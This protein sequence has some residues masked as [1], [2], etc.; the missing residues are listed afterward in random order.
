MHQLCSILLC[1]LVI[2]VV[3][4]IIL[5]VVWYLLH[6]W[7]CFL[8]SS[9]AGT[10]VGMLI[11]AVVL[12]LIKSGAVAL[13]TFLRRHNRIVV[14]FAWSA[15]IRR[16][17]P[18][19]LVPIH[20][21]VCVIHLRKDALARVNVHTGGVPVLVSHGMAANLRAEQAWEARLN[22]YG[23]ACGVSHYILVCYQGYCWGSVNVTVRIYLAGRLLLVLQIYH[24]IAL[25]KQ[26]I[27]PLS[28][29]LSDVVHYLYLLLCSGS[30]FLLLPGLL[31]RDAGVHGRLVDILNLK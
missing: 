22:D 6:L 30:C 26:F 31:S 12:T 3:A 7:Q 14:L 4:I 19:L 2:I 17:L 1:S 20:I 18:R 9:V 5:I 21:L 13:E 29:L 16:V 24:L 10:L 25:R 8:I 23:G 11:R 15:L 28:A 27:L